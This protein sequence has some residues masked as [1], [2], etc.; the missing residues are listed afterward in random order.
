MNE[1]ARFARDLSRAA[2]G[3]E[4]MAEAAEMRVARQALKTA[5]DLVPVDTGETRAEMRVVRRKSGGVAVESSTV[6]SVFQEF[7]TSRMAPNPFIRPA[8][9]KW[10]PQLSVEVEKIRDHVLRKLG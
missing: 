10:E 1:F 2:A 6:A 4:S 9:D 5:R 8:V 7:G 3:I